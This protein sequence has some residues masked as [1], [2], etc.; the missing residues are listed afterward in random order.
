MKHYFNSEL[1]AKKIKTKRIIELN[2]GLREVSKKTKVSPATICRLEN[3]AIPEM[4]TF[5]KMCNWL[6]SDPK[7]FIQTKK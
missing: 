4:E 3:D 2:I 7:E 6:G 1:F 5:L